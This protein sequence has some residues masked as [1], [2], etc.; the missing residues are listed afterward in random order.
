MSLLPVA[1][2]TIDTHK[3]GIN[4][5]DPQ[6]PGNACMSHL[7]RGPNART[8]HLIKE[9]QRQD[10]VA[11]LPCGGRHDVDVVDHDEPVHMKRALY[12]LF[13]RTSQ[14]QFSLVQVVG[15]WGLLRSQRSARPN[16]LAVSRAFYVDARLVFA[17]R[18]EL[19]RRCCRIRP[20]SYL[21]SM[22]IWE[23][24]F[25]FKPL[26]STP[27]L[28]A[29]DRRFCCCH[30][31]CQA[32]APAYLYTTVKAVKRMTTVS[33]SYLLTSMKSDRG[34]R[35]AENT[36]H[37]TETLRCKNRQHQYQNHKQTPDML[38]PTD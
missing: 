14:E 9:V 32:A 1:A 30:G 24:M 29:R 13:V 12:C 36:L 10:P 6:P 21:L 4:L 25:V 15:S 34:D 27:C 3:E 20:P 11:V 5:V 8:Q 23:V 18:P 38:K 33:L 2:A 16:R 31:T 35:D 19:I 26:L 37:Y 17:R 28:Q 7:K 22:R